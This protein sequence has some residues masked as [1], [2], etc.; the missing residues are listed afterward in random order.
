MVAIWLILIA[1][2]VVGM[3][4]RSRLF[5]LALSVAQLAAFVTQ[6]VIVVRMIR[7]LRRH[8]RGRR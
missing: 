7:D 4:V 8:D 2:Y 5:W 3:L 1:A 6:A